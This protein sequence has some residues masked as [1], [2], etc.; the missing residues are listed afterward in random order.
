MEKFIYTQ[1]KRETEKFMET[2]VKTGEAEKFTETQ[3][4]SG[5][6]EKFGEAQIKNETVNTVES[7]CKTKQR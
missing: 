4:K 5:E 7:R 3:I 6:A 2:H 1:I